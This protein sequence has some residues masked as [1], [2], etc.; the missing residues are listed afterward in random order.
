MFGIGFTEM[1]VIL[2]VALVVLGPSRL[3]E[4][5]RSLGKGYAELIRSMRD[6]RAEVDKASM[7]LDDER[8]IFQNPAKMVENIMETTFPES[9][10]PDEDR[11]PE[12]GENSAKS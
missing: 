7:S 11:K 6:V 4:I 8:K 2:V 9:K 10:K 12:D 3:P 1:M 5:A